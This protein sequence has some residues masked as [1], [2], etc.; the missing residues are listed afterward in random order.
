VVVPFRRW[1]FELR[2]RLGHEGETPRMCACMPPRSKRPRRSR[3]HW[4]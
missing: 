3:L 1:G 4:R 2:H